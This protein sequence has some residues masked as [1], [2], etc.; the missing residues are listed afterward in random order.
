MSGKVTTDTVELRSAAAP[1]TPDAGKYRFYVK[2]NGYPYYKDPSGVERAML[3]S[4]VPEAD[5]ILLDNQLVAWGL[6]CGA[7]YYMTF[8]TSDG[9]EEVLVGP[10]PSVVT[11]SR[12]RTRA[13]LGGWVATSTGTMTLDS[14][15]ALELNSS[16][17]PVRLAHDAVNQDVYIST[18]GTRTIHM[19]SVNA[20]L[21]AAYAAAHYALKSD[22]IGV[23]TLSD[24]SGNQ[25]LN[26]STATGAED[27]SLGNVVTNPTYHHLGKG[28]GTFGGDWVSAGTL[29]TQYGVE[30]GLT[31]IASATAY[32]NDA[33]SAVITNTTTETVFDK[34]LLLPP[35]TLAVARRLV[36]RASGSFT[37]TNL[38]VAPNITFRLRL[39]IGAGPTTKVLCT[40]PGTAILTDD[41]W[42][43]EYAGHILA[44]GSPSS[45]SLVG[46]SQMVAGTLPAALL[47]ARGTVA[48]I[49]T[50]QAMTVQVTAQWSAASA[51]NQV[52][53]SDLEVEF[54]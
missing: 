46:Q 12:L 40:L 32:V 30:S 2:N 37:E 7:D 9:S 45:R 15:G 17:G 23:F 22:T 10:D 25:Y 44:V 49:D 53:M 18:A 48:A 33:P 26:L 16:T 28:T 35:G 29:F 4:T 31:A 27:L 14:V 36:V 8:R 5:K 38:L 41:G 19:G 39:R 21:A 42:M 20:T 3:L 51:S 24:M 6:I 52:V 50:T 43:I 34:S 11:T 54:G 1:S 47:G 13:G